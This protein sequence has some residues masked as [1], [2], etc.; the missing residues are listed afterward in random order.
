MKEAVPGHDPVE[1]AFKIERPHIG[2]EPVGVGEALA[3]E[4]DHGG[5]R[6][7]AGQFASLLDEEARDGFAGPAAEIENAR[8]LPQ[9]LEHFVEVAALHKRAASIPV[10]LAGKALVEMV[11]VGSP[12]VLRHGG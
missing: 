2:N 6:V 3:A 5:G 10:I 11:H 12:V 1:P 7:D 8:A 9:V 4:D